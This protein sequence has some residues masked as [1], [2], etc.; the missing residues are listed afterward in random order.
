MG[1]THRR[2]KTFKEDFFFETNNRSSRKKKMSKEKDI[3]D[4]KEDCGDEE[5]Y[6]SFEK[7]GKRK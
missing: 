2:E 7:F 6:D 4:P 3:L 5:D 1:K